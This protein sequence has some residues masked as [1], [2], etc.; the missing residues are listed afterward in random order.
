MLTTQPNIRGRQCHRDESVADIVQ[1][2]LPVT[3]N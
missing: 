3:N 2:G 1:C